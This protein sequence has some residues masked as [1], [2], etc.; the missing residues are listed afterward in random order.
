[1]Y[2]L[3]FYK[4]TYFMRYETVQKPSR[5]KYGSLNFLSVILKKERYYCIE[6]R[7]KIFFILFL[8]L[9]IYLKNELD[10]IE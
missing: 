1:M 9:F 2:I 4:L 3:I 6:S 8:F 5:Y 10:F 7:S